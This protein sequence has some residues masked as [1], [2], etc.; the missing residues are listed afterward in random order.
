L[1]IPAIALLFFALFSD[2]CAHAQHFYFR[3]EIAFT[4]LRRL[5]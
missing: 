2:V 4:T 3:S 5:N 1:E